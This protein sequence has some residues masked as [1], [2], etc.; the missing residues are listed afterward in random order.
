M[1]VQNFPLA[2]VGWMWYHTRRFRQIAGNNMVRELKREGNPMKKIATVLAVAGIS[3]SVAFGEGATFHLKSGLTDIPT[4]WQDSSSYDEE[5]AP[6]AG[7]IVVLPDNTTAYVD[8]DTIAFVGTLRRIE[9]TGSN[10]CKVNFDISTN[11]TANCAINHQNT[12]LH[13]G[14]IVKDGEGTLDLISNFE[15]NGNS[16]KNNYYSAVR[17]VN[18]ALRMSSPASSLNLQDVVIEEN[19]TMLMDADKSFTA[20]SL[21]G[22]GTI[23]NDTGSLKSLTIG[24]D[25]R[26]RSVT[27]YVFSGTVL[28]KVN[29]Y[30]RLHT[31]YTGENSEIVNFK[32]YSFKPTRAD[33]LEYC[34]VTGVKKIGRLCQPSSTGT[35]NV[36]IGNAGRFLYIGEGESTDKAFTF[37]GTEGPVAMDGG[38]N[39]NVTFEGAWS[40][41]ESPCMRHL[42]L[43]GDGGTCVLDNDMT[44]YSNTKGTVTNYA[45]YITKRGAGEWF[46]KA[47]HARSFVDGPIAVEGGTVR[48]DSMVQAGTR[49][50]F[51]NARELFGPVIGLQ[52]NKVDYAFLLGGG[53]SS[54][55]TNGT[56]AYS[57][58]TN[59]W[60]NTRK[61]VINTA[62]TLTSESTGAVKWHGIE[63]GGAAGAKSLTL[64]GDGTST[65]YVYDLADGEGRP[66]SVAKEG[67]GNWTISGNLTFSGPL[68]VRGGTLN[69]IAAP[70]G[71]PY[72]Y[73]RLTVKENAYNCSRYELPV[74]VS[75][76]KTYYQLQEFALYD[77][78]GV[79]QNV[80]LPS[81]TN[82][83]FSV[84][85]PGQAAY[86]NEK[87]VK[88][89][90]TGR[91]LC[92]LFDDV[93]SS[94]AMGI[95]T[96]GW[97]VNIGM[98]PNLNDSNTWVSIVMRLTN[99]TPVIAS[100]D[101]C[102]YLGTNSTSNPGR[103]V[104]AY[105][106][107]G[108]VDGVH[109]ELVAEDLAAKVP[110][111]G[112]RW[113]SSHTSF[114]SGAK[115][116][117][118][119]F[120]RL[121]TV[122]NAFST[123]EN[124]SSV[125]IVSGGVLRATAPVTLKSGVTLT[126]DAELGGALEGFVLPASGTL[127]VPGLP[128]APTVE[129]PITFAGTEGLDNVR[130]WTLT[131]GVTPV[132][133][134]TIAVK[135]GRILINKKGVVISIR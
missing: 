35:N 87:M 77:E 53:T 15:D 135:N 30:N 5:A 99:S 34:G 95:P 63:V 52:S 76:D 82:V 60:V 78:D 121:G 43:C 66:L 128:D 11:A 54:A 42:I 39:G 134:R 18:G 36:Q 26:Y 17:I 107:D 23:R 29:I 115:R 56:L 14:T 37:E 119:T 70:V 110:G 69:V 84:L 4:K 116:T 86:D 94:S 51:G 3:A 131:S 28:G 72:S 79:R 65:N 88:P 102:N 19:G 49:C 71:T 129:L 83:M 1:A 64:G 31:H 44:G 75:S 100:Y 133:S 117:G 22:A 58:S 130:G 124:V 33:N 50:S 118:F 89:G 59:F 21:S 9:T 48:Y 132:T 113:Y 105:T 25:G 93:T 46:F 47:G 73:F 68:E 67:S 126:V 45:A 40:L 92:R 74:Y 16:G 80:F 111:G 57:G 114:S 81:A 125:S 55:P 101:L 109:W 103:G 41:S 112:P 20:M 7:D 85:E 104:T 90:A 27:P 127:S 96:G 123:L 13:K 38:A 61:I 91:F 98:Q 12:N 8:N 6:G 32:A 108:G 62:G 122:T 106:L 120:G 2:F 10:N 24:T 97:D